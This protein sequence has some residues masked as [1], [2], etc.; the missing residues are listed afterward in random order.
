MMQATKVGNKNEFRKRCTAFRKNRRIFYREAPPSRIFSVP[1][2]GEGVQG[3]HP[4]AAQAMFSILIPTYNYDCTA[5][6]RAL[7]QQ[8]AALRAGSGGRFNFEIIVADDGSTDAASL[9]KNRSIN[10]MEGCRLWESPRNLGRAAIRNRLAGQAAYPY[11]IFID[12]DALADE[13]PGFLR[14]YW[15]CATAAPEAVCGGVRNMP[16][17]PRPEVSLRFRYE[18]WLDKRRTASARSKHPYAE[19]TAFNLLIRRDT[20]FRIRFNEEQYKQYGYEDV[21]FGL[22][23]GQAGIPVEHID[24]PLIHAG[25]DENACFLEKTETALRTL[26]GLDRATRQGSAVARVAERMERLGLKGAM[27]RFHALFHGMERRNLLGKHPSLTVLSIYK[28][29]YYSSL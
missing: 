27:R 19:F 17:L 21:D 6:A 24:N 13:N 12:S 15:Q 2:P 26:H 4:K 25:L 16:R 29:G 14:R 11:L 20:F 18:A 23:L 5:L 1:L 3:S 10:L 28:L 7:S 8:G 22:R 9:Q